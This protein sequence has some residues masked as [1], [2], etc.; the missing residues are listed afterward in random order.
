[1]ADA[2]AALDYDP[3]VRAASGLLVT[4]LLSALLG[5]ASPA[6]S[7]P[8]PSLTTISPNTGPQT[9]SP[10]QSAE[11]D[12]WEWAAKSPDEHPHV[13]GEVAAHEEDPEGEELPA[14]PEEPA[15]EVGEISPDGEEVIDPCA[16]VT[17][18]EWSSWTGGA[19]T[20]MEPLEDGDAC[21]WIGP[22]DELRMAIGVFS[23]AGTDRWLTSEETASASPV[24]GLGE[25]AWWL[26]EWP[27]GQSSTL[28]VATDGIDLV[29]E[30]SAL[31]PDPVGMLEAAQ[32]FAAI[33][34]GRLP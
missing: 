11:A 34:L 5:C 31:Q 32:H 25:G 23:A 8:T 9:P 20:S 24:D 1:M 28:V 16:L 10:S 33:A 7:D 15:Q 18:A 17:E 22:G 12:G 4:M 13:L 3:E 14:G 2:G 29:I 27:L 26:E 6:L 21:G 30:M 19:D